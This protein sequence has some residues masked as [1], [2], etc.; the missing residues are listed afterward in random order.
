MRRPFL[1]V[2]TVL[3]ASGCASQ[4]IGDFTLL[5]TKNIDISKIDELE[6]V[7]SQPGRPAT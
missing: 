2:T 5:S 6:R 7:G 4:R 1:I 3:L